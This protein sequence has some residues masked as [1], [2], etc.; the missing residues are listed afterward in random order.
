MRSRWRAALAVLLPPRTAYASAR[1]GGS[2]PDLF[3]RPRRPDARRLRRCPPFKR[4][5]EVEIEARRL[6]VLLERSPAVHRLLV[7]AVDDVRDASRMNPSSSSRRDC[8]AGPRLQTLVHS[9]SRLPSSTCPRDERCARARI[10]PPFGR[11]SATARRAP[12]L[13]RHTPF[14]RWTCRSRWRQCVGVQHLVTRFGERSP[15]RLW[16]KYISPSS[17][18]RRRRWEPGQPAVR[19]RRSPVYCCCARAS[20]PS[21]CRCC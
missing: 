15:C 8:A 7:L 16:R 11:S 3:W 1:Y 20:A 18:A 14:R 9:S 4:D 12:P 6:R 10:A 5:A 13:L 2:L 17:D 21:V 19:R